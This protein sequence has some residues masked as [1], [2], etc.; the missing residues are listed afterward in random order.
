MKKRNKRKS[1]LRV[2][3]LLLLLAAILLV[4]SSYAWFTANKTVTVSTL[5]VNV[6]AQ[7]GLQISTNGTTW[8]SIISKTDI[9][10]GYTG[11]VNQLPEIL[12]P[13]SSGKTIDTST[14]YL[15]MFLGDVESNEN[16]DYVLTAT[17]SV[18]QAGTTGHFIAFDM[19]LKVA[20]DTDIEMTTTSG[21][22]TTDDK[23]KGIENASR[24]AFVVEGN[25]ANGAS[26]STIQEL[27][28]A[29][30]ATTYIWEPN[31]NIHTPAAISHALDVYGIT[32]TADSA[33]A[34]PYDGVIANITK[35]ENIKVGDA[36]AA[37]NGT[38]LATVT[39]DYQTKSGFDANVQVFSLKAGITKVRMYMWIEG[40]DVD[41]EDD[42][43]GSNIA[44]DLQLTVKDNI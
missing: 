35:D 18:E 44:F 3:L 25:V 30:P 22:K 42:A 21:V 10:T 28:A 5:D 17:P 36:T 38:K 9:T 16:G 32:T 20:T 23:S 4:S 31:F 12:T 11:S 2:S 37:K 39:T 14:G 6:E 43:S 19:F 15:N 34:V 26:A 7:N 24:I 29:T 41:C 13:V 27:K 1:N 40:Q 33:T 8:K